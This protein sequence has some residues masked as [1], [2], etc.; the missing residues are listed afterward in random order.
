MSQLALHLHDFEKC[1]KYSI[2]DFHSMC[3][4]FRRKSFTI[5]FEWYFVSSY[6]L[7]EHKNIVQYLISTNGMHTN[8]HAG[9]LEMFL[10]T[11]RYQPYE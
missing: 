3:R 5:L 2:R 7:K 8:V 10:K 6:L 9:T 4:M 11:C 1:I